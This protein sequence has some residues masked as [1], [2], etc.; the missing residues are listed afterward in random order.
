MPSTPSLTA[1]LTCPCLLF[2]CRSACS[3][4][5]EGLWDYLERLGTGINRNDPSTWGPDRFPPTYRGILN[6]LEVGH[7][8]FVWAVRKHPRL[9][10]VGACTAAVL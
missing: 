4:Y 7:Q 10:K 1:T 5:I 3:S 6:T 2:A 8:A 9:L